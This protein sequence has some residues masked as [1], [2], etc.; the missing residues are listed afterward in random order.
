MQVTEYFKKAFNKT[1]VMDG[2]ELWA[3]RSK[4][5]GEF[6]NGEKHGKGKLIWQDQST[7]QGSWQNG[8]MDGE[9]L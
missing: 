3:N 4:Y 8:L 6:L 2:I 5:E 1:D 9:G 7:Y